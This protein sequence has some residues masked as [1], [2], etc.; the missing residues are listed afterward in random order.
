MFLDCEVL[1]MQRVVAVKVD[2]YDYNYEDVEKGV[3]EAL[4]LLGGIDKFINPSDRVLLKPNMVGGVDKGT[5][6]TTHP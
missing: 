1:Q 3:N 5:F 2:S 6:V 4:A